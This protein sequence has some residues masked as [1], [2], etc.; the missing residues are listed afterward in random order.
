MISF[1]NRSITG[2]EGIRLN[3]AKLSDVSKS[4]PT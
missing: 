4:L 1:E 2:A 3:V